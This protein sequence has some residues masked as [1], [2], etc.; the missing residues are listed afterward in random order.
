MAQ[1]AQQFQQAAQRQNP[2]VF[3]YE[4]EVTQAWRDFPEVK[5]KVLFFEPNAGGRLIYPAPAA[6]REA[7]QQQINPKSIQWEI[8]SAR[9]MYGDNSIC[10][11]R[12]H[13]RLIFLYTVKHPHDV[14]DKTAPVA[15]E[16][17]FIFDHE[18]AHAIIP[19]ASYRDGEKNRAESIADAYAVIRH[20]Q[21]YGADSPAIDA[22]VANRAFDFVFREPR[23]GHS[24]FT[25]PV[26]EKILACRYDIDWDSLTPQQTGDLA[27]K[28][29]FEHEMEAEALSVLHKE[30]NAFHYK[31][32][33]I[34]NGDRIPVLTL[35]EKVLVTDCSNVFKYGSA[36]LKLCIDQQAADGVLAGAY[37]DNVRRKLAKK[38]QT[39][40]QPQPVPAQKTFKP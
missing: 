5:D 2:A 32:K 15:Q 37:W 17:T 40:I 9:K 21:R 14:T 20:F 18:L 24:H 35:A 27:R 1:T 11:P 7:I 3:D 8:E 25:S 22:I 34:E 10:Q 33:D 26:T 36:A 39:F 19:N 30:F 13:R 23:Y 29:V 4:R 31:A 16:T 38:Q 28:F 12:G 6:E